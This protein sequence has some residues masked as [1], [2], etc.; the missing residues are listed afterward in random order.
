[1]VEIF[2][3]RIT[4]KHNE[5]LIQINVDELFHWREKKEETL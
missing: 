1:M 2:L 5:I 4:R 3:E